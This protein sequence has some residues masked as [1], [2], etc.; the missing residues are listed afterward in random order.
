[1]NA[2]VAVE[3]FGRSVRSIDITG[4][5]PLPPDTNRM[6]AAG[7][8]EGRNRR[9]RS[10]GRRPCRGGRGRTGTWTPPAVVA[11]DG[12]FDE[13]G[14]LGAGRRIAAGAAPP[15]DLDGEVDVLAG[16]ESGERLVGFQRQRD[17]AGR[18][19]PHRD[20][21]GAGLAQ[22]PGRG[23]ELGVAVHAVGP[24]Q[25]RATGAPASSKFQ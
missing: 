8:P 24:G 20:H 13:C 1:M 23:D 9:R 12:E 11:A 16:T 3:T 14:A 7:R 10:R 22:R 18:L 17:A 2:I 4:V 21:L 25:Q 5:M 19:P 15:V 6:R